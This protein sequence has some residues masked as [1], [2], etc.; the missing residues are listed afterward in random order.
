MQSQCKAPL[1]QLASELADLARRLT[2]EQSA[3]R[4]QPPRL[5]GIRSPAVDTRHRLMVKYETCR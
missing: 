5:P 4:M 2:P 3:I 1:G